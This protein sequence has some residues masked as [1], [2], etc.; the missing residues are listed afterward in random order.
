[1]RESSIVLEGQVKN[2][3]KSDAG[4]LA[5]ML[6]EPGGSLHYCFSP[7]KNVSLGISDEVIVYGSSQSANKIRV[8]YL[9]NKTRNTENTL[10]ETK[11]SWTYSVSLI[12]SIIITI[13]FVISLLFLLRIIPV[14]VIGTIDSIFN[15]VFALIMVITLLPVLIIMW[16]LTS[17]FRKKRSESE[18]LAKRIKDVKKE[19]GVSEPDTLNTSQKQAEVQNESIS[20]GTAK[21][22]A[23]CGER[24]PPE[25]KF[26]SKCGAKWD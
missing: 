26:C 13:L 2:F 5:F 4:N 8:N 7:V 9:M 23:H 10:I 15:F 18:E 17:A 19:L 24:L 22:C 12:F 20:S 3:V 21:F 11:Q 14:S 6:E 16:V 25:A 1:M